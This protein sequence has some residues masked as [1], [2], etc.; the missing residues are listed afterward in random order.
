MSIAVDPHRPGLVYAG[1]GGY[2]VYRSTDG[3]DAW[4]VVREPPTPAAPCWP[5]I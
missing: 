4:T 2:H 3:G 1:D 5:S